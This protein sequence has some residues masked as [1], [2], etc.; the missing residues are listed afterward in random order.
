M[1]RRGRKSG[2][3]KRGGDSSSP[4]GRKGRGRAGATSGPGKKSGGKAGR[5]GRGGKKAAL[6]TRILEV[7]DAVPGGRP[8]PQRALARRIGLQAN[9]GRVLSRLLDELVSSGQVIDA[10]QGRFKRAR[11]DGLI[12]G[13]VTALESER[14]R[15]EGARVLDGSGRTW[16]TPRANEARVG[17]RV[18]VQPI[19]DVAEARG[20][21]VRAVGGARD[22]MIGVLERGHGPAEVT[23]YRDDGFWRITIPERHLAG[24]KAGEVVAVELLE[25]D[26]SQKKKRPERGRRPPGAE[27]LVGRVTERIG[28]PGSP[29]ADFRAVV[30]HRR[31]PVAFPPQVLS[32]LEGIPDTLPERAFERRRDL[33]DRPF[34]TID[35]ATARDH[36][37]AVFVEAAKGGGDWLWVAIADVA[38][39]VRPGT[40]VDREAERRG[41]SV[42]FPDRAIPMLPDRLSGDLCSLRPEADRLAMVVRLFVDADGRVQR[43]EFIEGVIRS[44]AKIA[45]EEAAEILEARDRQ[46]FESERSA[47]ILDQVTALGR[48]AKRLHRRRSR[49]GALDFELPEPVV[50]LDDR[51]RVLDIVRS[52]RSDA[53][54]AIEEAMLAANRAVAQLLVH[55]TR[56]TIHRVHESPGDEALDELR[57]LFGQFG[58]LETSRPQLGVR[59]LQQALDAARGHRAERLIHTQVLRSM[60]QARYGAESLG[61]FALAFEAYLHFTS[62]IRRYADLVVHRALKA[63]ARA[64]PPA[65]AGAL[66]HL[67]VRLSGLERRAVAAERDMLDLKKAALMAGRLGERFEGVVTGAAEQGVYVTLDHPFVEGLVPSRVLPRGAVYDADRRAWR[68]AR[69]ETGLGIGERIEVQVVGVDPLKGWVN[70]KLA[71]ESAPDGGDGGLKKER[72]RGRPARGKAAPSRGRTRRSRP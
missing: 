66:S 57:E 16:R 67:A 23:P 9:G 38:H 48:V 10:G 61:H 14:G 18:L 72:P 39:Y 47:E 36:D 34:L 52:E 15:D 8:V 28:R 50:K 64:R 53:H 2:K 31:L 45:Y 5:S 35:P 7:L 63:R 46:G 60:K 58:L 19:G 11:R 44:H 12:E 56:P 20:E 27:N 26:Q 1:A 71:G 22:H 42:Y 21:I 33:R 37:D 13:R 43:P 41:N 65:L 6:Q 3:G 25:S 49:H 17:D 70:F 54:R 30:W 40:A 29:E 51:G 68:S 24:A 69:G 59:E 32:E 62:P 4:G 55:E